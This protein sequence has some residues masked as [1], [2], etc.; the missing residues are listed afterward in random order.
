MTVEYDRTG[1]WNRAEEWEP[2]L[3]E[4]I[5]ALGYADGMGPIELLAVMNLHNI[6][7]R[8]TFKN[9]KAALIPW[10]HVSHWR[11]LPCVD[12]PKEGVRWAPYGSHS[13]SPV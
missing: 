12:R 4:F 9:G 1:G 7:L 6:W 2:C 11:V 13:R 3:T 10:I 8:V 5:I